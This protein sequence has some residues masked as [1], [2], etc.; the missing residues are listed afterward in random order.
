[1]S[2]LVYNVLQPRVL[3]QRP[4]LLLMLHG[5]GSDENDLFSFADELNDRFLVVSVR[6][7]NRLPWG[8]N[9]WYD[10]N[11]TG[12]QDRFGDP[13]QALAS[14]KLVAGLIAELKNKFKTGKTVLLGFS[15]G[16]ILSYALSLHHPELIDKALTL[17]GYIFADIMPKSLNNSLTDHL[18]FFMSHGTQDEVI[19]I[20]WARSARNWIDGRQLKHEYHE[21][22][23]GHGINPACFHDMMRW[24]SARYPVLGSK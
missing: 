23:M 3:V 10:I 1:M 9:A 14:M 19:P 18:E 7:P 12:S 21:Y 8:G 17:S 11:F 16:A 4:P 2:E 24:I 22:P 20:D 5:Y 13:E 15:Q 6:A